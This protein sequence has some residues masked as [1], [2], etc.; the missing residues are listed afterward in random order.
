MEAALIGPNGRTTLG[1]TPLTIGRLPSNQLHL[2]DSQASSRHA[3]IRP[4]AGR[5]R[6][7]IVDL[8]STNGTFV[9]EQRIPPNA[10]RY[11]NS[12]DKIRIGETSF[13]YES[14]GTVGIAPTVY[15]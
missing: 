8:G 6:Y 11:L 5:Q 10:P 4:D 12:G 3:E 9:N 1:T 15:A 7:S 2:T 13:T 14:S